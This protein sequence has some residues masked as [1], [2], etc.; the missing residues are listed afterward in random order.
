MSISLLDTDILSE[1]LKRQN[2]T[3]V[4][5]AVDYLAQYQQF[6]ISAM[7]RYEVRRGLK[8]KQA[9]TQLA[10]FEKFCQHSIVYAITDEILERTADLWGMG[11]KGGHSHRDADLLIAATALE[12]GCVLVT[13]NT[14]HFGW[15][16]GLTLKD[17]RSA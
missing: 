3:V 9:A 12:H 14:Q 15:I 2:A 10:R 13:G 16:P 7:T 1:V 6:A 8:E 17:W 11:R 4:K 5:H